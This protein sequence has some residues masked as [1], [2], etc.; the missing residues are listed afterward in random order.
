MPD[1]VSVWL[2]GVYGTSVYVKCPR[3]VGAAV[4]REVRSGEFARDRVAVEEQN[5]PQS[6]GPLAFGKNS[7][8]EKPPLRTWQP[9][10]FPM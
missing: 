9:R 2:S 8:V 1:P 6:P 10:S 7:V 3:D 5:V 4:V